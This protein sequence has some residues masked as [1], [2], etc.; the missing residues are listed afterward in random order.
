MKLN[1][2]QVAFLIHQVT[3][4]IPRPDGSKVASWDA[5][6]IN[7]KQNAANAVKELM[8]SSF[9]T[10]K[11]HHDLW[12]RPLITDGWTRGDY[13]EENKTHPCICEYEELI[14]SE[15]LKDELWQSLTTVFKPYYTEDEGHSSIIV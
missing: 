8:N 7:A 12:M 2:F 11:E 14:P 15:K 5:L 4:Q 9:T 10:P 1:S 6:S 13:N 3:S